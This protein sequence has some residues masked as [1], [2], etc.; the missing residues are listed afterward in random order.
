LDLA[1]E[2][3]A[4]EFRKRIGMW[5]YTLERR[6]RRVF[7]MSMSPLTIPSAHGWLML[8]DAAR[9]TPEDVAGVGQGEG[10]K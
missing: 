8:V 2:D 3:G 10:Q 6:C 4:D 1:L 5:L 7:T 9:A